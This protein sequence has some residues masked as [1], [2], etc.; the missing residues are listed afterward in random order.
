MSEIERPS[1]VAIYEHVDRPAGGVG[2]WRWTGA[3]K[4]DGYGLYSVRPYVQRR[5]HRIVYELTRGPVPEGL[6]LDHLCKNKICVNPDHLEPVSIAE[7]VRRAFR[8]QASCVNGHE[9]TEANTYRNPTHGRRSCREC[10]RI[11]SREVYW[12]RRGD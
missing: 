5:A 6:V 12:S 10:A 11:R 4:S 1:I 7:N 9:Y 8:E 2:C 3:R